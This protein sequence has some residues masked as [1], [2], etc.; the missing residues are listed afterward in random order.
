MADVDATRFLNVDLELV[1]AVGLGPLTTHLGENVIVLR[2]SVD[3]AIRTVWLELSSEPRDVDDA[4]RRYVTLI[5]ALPP[6]LRRLWDECADRC[7]NVGIQAGRTPHAAAF[8]VSQ[9]AVAGA[10]RISARFEFTVYGEES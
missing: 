1:A 3:E 10:A 8:C 2:D 7:L 5:E 9:F 6:V 4:V